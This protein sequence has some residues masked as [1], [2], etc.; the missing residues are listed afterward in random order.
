MQTIH[1]RTVLISTQGVTNQ[2]RI[3][4][5]GIQLPVRFIGQDKALNRPPQLKFK[6]VL[7]AKVMKINQADFA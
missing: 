5:S 7:R 2:N 1:P 6:G 4:F 3:V